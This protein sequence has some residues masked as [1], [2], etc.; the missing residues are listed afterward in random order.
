V[1]HESYCAYCEGH[2][3]CITLMRDKAYAWRSLPMLRTRESDVEKNDRGSR[4]R[5]QRLIA[6]HVK[7]CTGTMPDLQGAVDALAQLNACDSQFH[8]ATQTAQYEARPSPAPPR[9]KLAGDPPTRPASSQQNRLWLVFWDDHGS[10]ND[11][12]ILRADAVQAVSTFCVH[13]N[14]CGTGFQRRCS[15]NVM[16]CGAACV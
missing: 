7:R 12:C 3:L 13:A 14:A 8:N 16:I 10:D 6:N 11:I 1:A 15:A 4:F 9:L 2:T 5:E